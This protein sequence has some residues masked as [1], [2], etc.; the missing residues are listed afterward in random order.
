MLNVLLMV[1]DSL[2]IIGAFPL[3]FGGYGMTCDASAPVNG[4]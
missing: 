2:S 4:S 3:G 1:L